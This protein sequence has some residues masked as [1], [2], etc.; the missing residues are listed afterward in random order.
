MQFLCARVAI[1]T[2]TCTLPS[3]P[4][5][6]LLQ[7]F[8]LQGFSSSR[9][10]VVWGCAGT[11]HSPRARSQ[12]A[13]A[14]RCCRKRRCSPA[15]RTRRSRRLSL[16]TGRTTRRGAGRTGCGTSPAEGTRATRSA[17][18]ARAEATTST[19]RPR[20]TSTR[21]FVCGPRCVFSCPPLWRGVPANGVAEPLLSLASACYRMWRILWARWAHPACLSATR[22]AA[23]WWLDTSLGKR[24]CT[25]PRWWV[26]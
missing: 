6:A 26:Q 5:R 17:C 23:C 12:A 2:D 20:S 1:E 3:E 7:G 13:C 4:A 19:A 24:P 18:E 8:G 14:W 21:R 11:S 15:L 9:L 16:C 25:V 22:S 10:T